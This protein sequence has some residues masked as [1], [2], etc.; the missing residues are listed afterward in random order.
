M[1][2]FKDASKLLSYLIKIAE[3]ISRGSY[4]RH[5]ELFELTKTGKYPKLV[6]ELAES[7]GMMMVKVEAREFHL[8][9]IIGKL[10]ESQAELAAARER[11]DRENLNLK[12]NLRDKYSTV[13]IL[14]T[15]RAVRDL[16]AKLEQVADTPVNVLITGET[17]TG[18]ELVAKSLHFNSHRLHKPFVAINCAAIPEPL[19]ESEL[20]G[21]EKGVASGVERR[22][23]RIQQ[24]DGGSL[25]LDEI[26]DMP[27]AA[28]AKMLRVIEDKTVEMVGGRSSRVVDVRI[29]A[30]TNK[31]LKSEVE[32]GNFRGDLFYRLN[33]VRLHISPLRERKDDVPLLLDAFLD[34]YTRKLSKP[35]MRFS[36]DVIDHLKHYPWP[37][38]V[39]ELE[40]E[41][42]RAVA[43]AHSD[44][45]AI[46]NLSDEVQYYGLS[47][48]AELQESPPT[49]TRQMEKKMI[50]E[51]LH[52]TKGNKSETARRLGISR[53]GLR[54]KIKR[55]GLEFRLPADE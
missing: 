17:G 23:G 55:Y 28:Q 31:D 1:S 13:R 33:V 34:L 36:G 42:E 11:L 20:F 35:A 38:N 27:L 6:T 9:Q 51:A 41:V 18:K 43:L 24:A 50:M 47:K 26:G 54:K 37:G 8:E 14:G 7:F 48:L 15:S 12:Q 16:I 46:E 45:I 52:E 19:L 3:D 5:K 44:V 40:N 4:G 22:I 53:E 32:K 49:N 2:D 30:A 25:F 39:R 29:I 21:I 10:R